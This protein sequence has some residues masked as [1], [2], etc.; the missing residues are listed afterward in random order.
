VVTSRKHII[1][2]EATS[3][4]VEV[5]ASAAIW[6]YILC[7]RRRVKAWIRPILLR[8]PVIISI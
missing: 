2:T 6:L 5:L 7:R 8:I 3:V 1:C 4:A